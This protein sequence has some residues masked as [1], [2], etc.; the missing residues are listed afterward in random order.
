[1]LK[2]NNTV[3]QLPFFLFWAEPHFTGVRFTTK[4]TLPLLTYEASCAPT[5]EGRK[6]TPWRRTKTTRHITLAA[7]LVVMVGTHAHEAVFARM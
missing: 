7:V 3:T 5:Q 1:M 4:F 2:A 6:P